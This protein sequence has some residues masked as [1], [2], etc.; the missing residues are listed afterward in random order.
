M[1]NLLK[2]I[3]IMAFVGLVNVGVARAESLW[4]TGF[5]ARAANDCGAAAPACAAPAPSCAAPSCAAP[6]PSCCEPRIT[7]NHIC[8]HRV[9]CCGCQPP[10]ETV[11]CVKDP[12]ACCSACA[13]AI[14]VCLPACCTGEPSVSDHVGLFGRGVVRYD[15]C[16]GLS[17]KIIFRNNGDIAV[18]YIGA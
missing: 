5:I 6:A 11:L 2:R 17:I 1:N 7:Y 15:Y 9:C 4:L 13:V 10:V 12:A 14:P 8:R 16:C 3:A 18:T